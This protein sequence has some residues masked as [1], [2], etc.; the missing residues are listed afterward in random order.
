MNKRELKQLIKP[1]VKECIREALLEEGMLSTVIA[2]VVKGTSGLI[3]EVSRTK[4]QPSE[5]RKQKIQQTTEK[6][7]DNSEAAIRRLQERKSSTS[8]TKKKLL[9]AIGIGSFNGVNLFEGTEALSNSG[10]PS[11]GSQEVGGALSGY[12]PDDSGVDISG[13]LNIAG[14]SWKKIN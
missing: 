6:V 7:L 14:G 1:I 13:L 10:N 12:A 3:S 2:E 9:E 5:P 8:T 11:Q 4:V